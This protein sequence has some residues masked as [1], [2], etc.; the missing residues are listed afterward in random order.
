[1]V[2]SFNLNPQFKFYFF[3][4]SMTDNNNLSIKIYCKNIIDVAYIYIYIGF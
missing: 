3:F 2:I 1:M 4:S